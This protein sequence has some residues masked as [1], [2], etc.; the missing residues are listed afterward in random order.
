ML[1]YFIYKLDNI[2]KYIFVSGLITDYF[3]NL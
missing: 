3:I 2:L 1:Y